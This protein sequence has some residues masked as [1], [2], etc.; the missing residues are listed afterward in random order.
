MALS[1]TTVKQMVP[2]NHKEIWPRATHGL[3]LQSDLYP[4]LQKTVLAYVILDQRVGEALRRSGR[5]GRA[6]RSGRCGLPR[7]VPSLLP[8]IV[9]AHANSATKNLGP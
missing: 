9:P 8:A 5:C 4:V 1:V 2:Q 7:V 6:V 3:F